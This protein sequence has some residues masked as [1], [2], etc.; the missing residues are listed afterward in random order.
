VLV[1]Y[2]II[3]LPTTARFSIYLKTFKFFI[4][5]NA[6]IFCAIAMLSIVGLS[7]KKSDSTP[8]PDPT[9]TFKA[10]LSGASEVPANA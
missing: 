7:C 8:P 4:M 1:R 5:K 2:K 3:A 6:L 9:T 10:T